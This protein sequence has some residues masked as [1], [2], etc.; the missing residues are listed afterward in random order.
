MSSDPPTASARSRMPTRPRCPGRPLRTSGRTP[1][2]S[3]RTVS[4]SSPSSPSSCTLTRHA[5]AWCSA[6]ISA[7][8]AIMKAAYS[9]SAGQR[10][11][12][13]RGSAS[14]A[15]SGPVDRPLLLQFVVDGRCKAE[16]VEQ[17]RAQFFEHV[18]DLAVRR[19]HQ[20]PDTRAQC[21]GDGLGGRRHRLPV[22]PQRRQRL[23]EFVVQ[24][25]RQAARGL[26]FL[27]QQAARQLEQFGAR[28]LE[29]ALLRHPLGDVAQDRGQHRRVAHLGLRDRGLQL[30]HAA[31]G[32]VARH[33][34]GGHRTARRLRRR[35]PACG[36]H[37]RRASRRAAAAPSER[38]AISVAERP[39]MRSAAGLNST[40]R[41]STSALMIA[42]LALSTTAASRAWLS[43]SARSACERS[44]MSTKVATMPSKRHAASSS[45]GR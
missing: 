9:T 18:P 15:S 24:R 6:L 36:R 40:T 2:P 34:P 45:G 42:S 25:L 43:A 32:V 28:D 12:C 35:T 11:H 3:S 10:W 13:R 21:T 23:A 26:L 20:L 14:S 39:K 1:T 41:P 17:R 19:D 7:S 29:R 30:E 5:A 4:F 27:L 22:Q 31:V 38:P 44:V 33:P 8:R 16:V 37:V